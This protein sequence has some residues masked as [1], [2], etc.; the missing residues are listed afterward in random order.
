MIWVGKG[1]TEI[2]EEKLDFDK[3]KAF[4]KHR[5]KYRKHKLKTGQRIAITGN[6]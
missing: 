1:V 3:Y 4:T 5:I 2:Q 6:S